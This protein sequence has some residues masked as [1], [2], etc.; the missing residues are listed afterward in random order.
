MANPSLQDFKIIFLWAFVAYAI[1]NVIGI[2]F[3]FLFAALDISSFV[4]FLPVVFFY[5]FAYGYCAFK[6]VR[7]LQKRTKLSWSAIALYMS[8][9]VIVIGLTINLFIS[10][11]FGLEFHVSTNVA[12]TIAVFV[13]GYQARK[14]KEA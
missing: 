13:G 5:A 8:G 6:A 10:A 12:G 11:I 14:K 7:K 1:G 2:L 4:L 3:K 9:A